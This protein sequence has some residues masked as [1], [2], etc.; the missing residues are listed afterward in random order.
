MSPSFSRLSSLRWSG[1]ARPSS[2]VFEHLFQCVD[3][4]PCVTSHPGL[5]LVELEDLHDKEANDIVRFVPQSFVAFSK[6]SSQ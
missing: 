6:V 1:G 5:G 3:F 4:S 2:E